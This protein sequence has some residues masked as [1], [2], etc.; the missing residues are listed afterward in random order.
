MISRDIIDSVRDASAIEEVIGRYQTLH[1]HGANYTGICP[2][3]ADS[4]PSLHVNVR[5]RIYKC[6]ACGESGDVF[7]YVQH[8]E[9]VGFGEA[10]RLLAQRAHIALPDEVEETDEERRARLEREQLVRRNEEDQAQFVR[11]RAWYDSEDEGARCVH[12]FSEYLAQRGISREAAEAFGMGLAVQGPFRRRITYPLYT[13]SGVLAGWTGRTLDPS[14]PAKYKNSAD[15]V[16]FHKDELLFGLRQARAAI[17]QRG[18]CYIVEG[19]NDV[20]RMWMSGRENTVAGSGTAFSDKQVRLL[21]RFC[22]R[23]TLMYDGDAAGRKATL[24]TMGLMLQA[25]I[26]VYVCVLPDGEDPDSW[27]RE[28]VQ[29]TTTDRGMADRNLLMANST[30]RWHEYLAQVALP[31]SDSP[32]TNTQHVEQVAEMIAQ[33]GDSIL[34]GHLL[35]LVAQQYRVERRELRALMNKTKTQQCEWESGLYGLDEAEDRKGGELRLTFSKE[36]FMEEMGESTPT[37]LWVGGV[38]KSMVQRLREYSPLVVRMDE[39]PAG[40]SDEAEGATELMMRVLLSMHEDGQTVLMENADG[41]RKMLADYYILHNAEVLDDEMLSS[42]RTDIIRRCVEVIASC[43]PTTREINKDTYRRALHLQADAYNKILRGVLAERK[44]KAEEAK[45]KQ[46]LSGRTAQTVL[47]G[48]PDYVQQDEAL[49]NQ[50]DQYGFFPLMSNGETPHP[51]AYV[52]KNERGDGHTVVSDFYM[53]ALLFV[54]PS[55]DHSKRVIR[56]NHLHGMQQY[57]EWPSDVFVSLA[58]MRKRLFASGAYNFNGTP[59]QWDKIRQVLSYNF[60]DCYEARVFG[61]QPEG[62]LMLPNAVYYRRSAG[63]EESTAGTSETSPEEWRLEYMDNLGVAEVGG[64]RFYSP[65]AS[66]IRLGGRQVDNP[67][68]EDTYAYYL[69]PTG[70]QRME[71]ADWAA[72]MDT[73]FGVNRNGR[74]AVLFAIACCFRDLIYSIVGSFTAL[75]F[76]GPTGSGKTELAYGIRGLWMRRRAA[77]FNLN[78]GTDA[79]FFIMLE[80]FRNMPVIME[81]YNDQGISDVK[82]QG[83]KAAVYD[84]KGR[85]K[86]KDASSKSLDTS[87][88]N[89]A[90]ILLG[91]DT[92]QQDDGS[93]SNRVIICEVPK[94]EGGYSAAETENFERLKRQAEYGMG[95]IL[96]DIVRHRPLFERYFKRIFTEEVARL[97]AE[98]AV[99]E[100]RGKD[101]LERV[102]HSIAILSATCRLIQ[103][104]GSV[105]LPWQYGEFYNM[106]VDKVCRQMESIGTTSK[107]GNFFKTLNTL[108]TR[109][110]VVSGREFTLRE[111]TADTVRVK[112]GKEWRNVDVGIGTKLLYLHMDGAHSAY[113]KDVRG[114]DQLS[115]QTLKNY[116]HANSAFL[117]TVDSWQFA[118]KEAVYDS[119]L[120]KDGQRS[121]VATRQM[122]RRSLNSSAYVF[123]YDVLQRTY[124]IDYER[125]EVP[126]LPGLNG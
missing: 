118:W 33:V 3:H 63:G 2:F 119:Y 117:G 15:S 122:M 98:E 52:F 53:E 20:I 17:Q 123:L 56:L 41:E 36:R 87:K 23:V 115:K 111:M 67:Y 40:R 30:Y 91:Q 59:Q 55:T 121:D 116:I 100:H 50:Y 109:G 26:E 80:H 29:S 69:E 77:V 38:N 57:V 113:C 126:D 25:G 7:K 51:V 14:S 37:L 32:E 62:F 68:E 72:L 70:A 64:L 8:A 1:R 74:W 43:D 101:G 89:A 66:S 83:L 71:F 31:P 84:D 92:P 27:L 6:F 79:A 5:M 95:N 60:T 97:R 11:D 86:V 54:D 61:W 110:E 125:R 22:R 16:L 99:N 13:A 42:E 48:V 102:I 78:S 58:D 18:E 124:D 88:T 19:Q 120:D 12:P 106:A 108:L 46:E 44:D 24:R 75:C 112:N 9:G 90:P 28:D 10:L 114:K 104:H 73:V 105:R 94:K 103:E 107:M 49:K 35:T 4:T 82:F 39:V 21:Q 47:F 85:T 65:A 45:R 93:L 34:R 96:C 76:A 81:E